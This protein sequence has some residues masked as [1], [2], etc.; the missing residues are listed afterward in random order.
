[1]IY[2]TKPIIASSI[3]EWRMEGYHHGRSKQAPPTKQLGTNNFSNRQKGLECVKWEIIIKRNYKEF[4]ST[5][6]SKRRVQVKDFPLS[7]V[8]VTSCPGLISLTEE[9]RSMVYRSW[10]VNP[11]VSASSPALKQRGMTPIPTRLL[12]WIL[13]K[14]LAITAFTPCYTKH[15][16]IRYRAKTP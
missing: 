1:M 6:V 5:S 3:G 10:P 14:L 16:S 12:R 8:T 15:L 13:S 7:V 4:V 2:E 11:K 9:G